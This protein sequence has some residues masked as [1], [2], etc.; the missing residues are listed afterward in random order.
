MTKPP[1]KVAPS[2]LPRLYFEL[3]RLGARAEGQNVPWHLGKPSPEETLVLASDASRQDPR[4][5]WVLVDLL[6]RAYD[7][8][9]PL[10][11]RRAAA[12]GRFP[13]ALGV[14]FEFAKQAR[15]SQELSDM[16]DFVTKRLSRA[17][18]ESFFIGTHALG[19]ALARRE[20]EESLAE[21]KRWGYLSREVPVAKELGS[22][23]RGH[24]G[25]AE[26]MNVLRRVAESRESFSLADYL[27]ALGERASLRQASRDL[28][29]APFLKKTGT[30]R[31]ARYRLAKGG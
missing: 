6:A 31:G 9:H 18:G 19:G 4:L 28:A 21:Y 13:A 1:A 24:L 15:P 26:R 22:S 30:T 10:L 5:L 27:E 11:L 23:A 16:A 17:R 20:A 8:F 25:A 7:R 14:A 2:E 3:A 29:T 12:N